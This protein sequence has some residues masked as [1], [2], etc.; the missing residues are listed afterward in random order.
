MFVSTA[1]EK[2]L[3]NSLAL[4]PGGAQQ[5][6]TSTEVAHAHTNPQTYIRV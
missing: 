5:G 1:G 4:S 6:N 2:A 3:C